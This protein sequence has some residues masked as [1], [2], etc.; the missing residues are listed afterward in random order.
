MSQP[1]NESNRKTTACFVEASSK[2]D[3]LLFDFRSS[4]SD[5][6]CFFMIFFRL[7]FTA[8]TKK[9]ARPTAKII[10]I[11]RIYR[12]LSAFKEKT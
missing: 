6:I 9:V 12:D 2:E 4:M 1:K 3:N 7:S 10:Q 11:S 8:K 5:I